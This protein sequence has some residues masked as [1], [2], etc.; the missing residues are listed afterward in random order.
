MNTVVATFFFK[1]GIALD[2]SSFLRKKFLLAR[3]GLHIRDRRSMSCAIAQKIL[4][5][6][7][8]INRDTI[9]IYVDFRS[10][11]ETT[12]LIAEL[13]RRGKRVVV[14]VTLVKEKRLL[15][16]EIRDLEK[17]LVPGYCSIPEPRME[18]RKSNLVPGNEVE[19][20]ILPGSVFDERG[21]RLGYGG[22]FYDRF[23]AYE[24]PRA[25]RIG[26]AFELQMV[27]RLSLQAH[28][29]MLDLIV[30]EKRIIQGIR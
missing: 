30:T 4:L 9:F 11:V 26:L 20:I 1:K 29:E 14:P 22:G 15:P 3:D 17:D 23:M 5:L 25:K 10:E 27:D 16:V 8:L 28:D 19:T 7:E 6:E 24:A 12:L 21:G 2:V 13:I 18:L